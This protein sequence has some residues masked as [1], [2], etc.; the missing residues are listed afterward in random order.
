V[1]GE[2]A[3]ARSEARWKETLARAIDD[4]EALTR[5]LVAGSSDLVFV[6]D[7]NANFKFVSPASTR[8]LGY[9]PDEWIGR[10]AFELLHPDDHGIAAESLVTS[11]A[12]GSGL[13]EPLKLRVRHASG[14]WRHVEIVAN[15]LLDDPH[16]AGLV[17]NLRDL[18][19]R[20]RA[21]VTARRDQKRFEQFFSRA[22]IGLAIVRADGGFLRV[23]EAFCRMLGRPMTEISSSSAR[24]FVRG[25]DALAWDRAIAALFAGANDTAEV[26][27][28]YTR[29]DGLDVWTR[30]TVSVVRDDDGSQYAIA[31]IED[32][33]ERR[34][35]VEELR[36]A[37]THDRLTGLANRAL[38]E[39]HLEVLRARQV[40]VGAKAAV[41]FI[42]LDYFKEVNDTFGHAG[43]DEL[44]VQVADR[45]RAAVRGSDLPARLGGDEFVVLSGDLASVGEAE[46]LAQR[47]QSALVRPYRLEQGTARVGASVGVTIVSPDASLED[48]LAEADA[49][50]YRAKELGRNR[51]EMFSDLVSRERRE[52][53]A[54]T[55]AVRDLLDVEVLPF[56]EYGI[57][58]IATREPAGR[59]MRIGCVRT[60]RGGA[61]EIEAAARLDLSLLRIATERIFAGDGPFVASVSG[62][63]LAAP[64]FLP[65]VLE[66][67]D[68]LGDRAPSLQLAIGE[69][70]VMQD[71]ARA[72]ATFDALSGAGLGRAIDLVGSGPSCVSL[73]DRLDVGMIVLDAAVVAALD[74]DRLAALVIAA[75]TRFARSRG[76]KVMGDGVR[77]AEELGPLLAL[78]CD[79]ASGAAFASDTWQR[80][81]A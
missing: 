3:G 51:V 6:V 4:R 56:D 57:T 15:N 72:E 10:N 22:P 75:S 48:L 1:T 78:G 18:S 5:A 49:A 71:L 39:S 33:S 69:G 26:E 11:T 61:H 12:V 55:V 60:P 32:V 63:A 64:M 42:D 74:N 27:L 23:N 16:V 24:A 46:F 35:L 25:E 36:R 2:T 47:L 62:A 53:L 7:A 70:F 19:D 28:Q 68:V 41:L 21:E 81:V 54:R 67:A 50:T 45:L 76:V 77:S 30:A 52:R 37:A 65:G 17:I 31:Q 73:L 44:L 66:I 59:R 29:P 38:L 58:E 80:Q 14:E 34:H 79:Y 40:R 20:R 43:G 13:R 8:I 9:A